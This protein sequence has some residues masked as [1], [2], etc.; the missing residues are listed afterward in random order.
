[1]RFLNQ[2]PARGEIPEYYRRYLQLVPDDDLVN[3]LEGQ[4]DSTL[5]LAGSLDPDRRYEPGKWS[6]REVLVHITDTE[7]VFAYR[8]LRMARGDTTPLP[9]FEQDDYVVTADL[10]HRP[11]TDV[12]AELRAVRTATVALFRGLSDEALLRTGTASG[13]T[14]TSRGIAWVIVGHE[15]HHRSV[16]EE[17]YR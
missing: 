17:R 16:L 4:L 14:F 1:M 3:R 10:E 7:R 5:A 6:V 9:G 11:Y 12:E 15:L 8:A 13:G 2:R